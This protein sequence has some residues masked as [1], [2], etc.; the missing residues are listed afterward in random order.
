MFLDKELLLLCMALKEFTKISLH[1]QY[2][3]AGTNTH[4]YK[5]IELCTK[6][7]M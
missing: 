4:S 5:L 7:S 1:L 6:Y 2:L 3:E